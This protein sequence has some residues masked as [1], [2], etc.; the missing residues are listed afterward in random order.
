MKTRTRI[1]KKF[2]LEFLRRK[3]CC[4]MLHDDV[5]LFSGVHRAAL[6]VCTLAICHVKH[7]RFLFVKIQREASSEL[8]AREKESRRV[9]TCRYSPKNKPL[10]NYS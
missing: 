2:D 10:P 4:I 9:G 1:E 7:A 8:W 6:R 3:S 5:L